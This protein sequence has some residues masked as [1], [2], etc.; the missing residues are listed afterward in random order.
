MS[1]FALRRNAVA[2]TV[3]VWVASVGSRSVIVTVL[4]ALTSDVTGEPVNTVT[5]LVRVWVTTTMGGPAALLKLVT[6]HSKTKEK[7][8]DGSCGGGGT[9]LPPT[10]SIL[11]IGQQSGCPA[12]E[13]Q[14]V[15]PFGQV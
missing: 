4:V 12:V 5:V 2:V 6:V 11:P 9:Q 10:H 8:Y 13:R 7:T 3:A 1:L 15:R 14:Q